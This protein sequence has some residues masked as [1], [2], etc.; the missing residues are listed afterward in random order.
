MIR[1]SY[2]LPL[3]PL[4]VDSILHFS[5]ILPTSF[6]SPLYE[7]SICFLFFSRVLFFSR[8]PR[9]LGFAFE[10]SMFFFSLSSPSFLI[11]LL[12]SL[13]S[14]SHLGLHSM[15]IGVLMV[16]S[17]WDMSGSGLVHRLGIGYRHEGGGHMEAWTWFGCWQ[18]A[19]FSGGV[20][21]LAIT[22]FGDD[23][24]FGG[25]FVLTVGLVQ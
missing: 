1:V 9:L 21:I 22:S 18:S 5:T 16:F 11:L 6:S 7:R 17:V 14:S 15:Q 3:E 8:R 10:Q 2:L 20:F 4:F 12:L 23:G 25:F 24:S 13:W 19:F